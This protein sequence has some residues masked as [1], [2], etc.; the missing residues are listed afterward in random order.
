MPGPPVRSL[1]PA[2][3]AFDPVIQAL[4]KRAWAGYVVAIA[5]VSSA[6]LVRA[7][8]ELV[9]DFYYL[10]LVPAVVATAVVA[11]RRATAIAVGLAIAAKLLLVDRVSAV[12]AAVHASLFTAVT[13]SQWGLSSGT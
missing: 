8:L 3:V 13:A 6:V 10:P 7:G 2:S 4:S 9:G 5:T 1:F 12:D 11:D